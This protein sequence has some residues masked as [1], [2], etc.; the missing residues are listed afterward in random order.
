[1][2]TTDRCPGPSGLT[3]VASPCLFIL[4]CRSAILLE[5][6]Y[7]PDSNLSVLVKRDAGRRESVWLKP[8]S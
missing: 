3:A 8:G 5:H 6:G 4:R 7:P 1:M 2:E